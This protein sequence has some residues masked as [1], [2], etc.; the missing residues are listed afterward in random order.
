MIGGSELK[1]GMTILYNGD[2]CRVEYFQHVK[3]GKG[4][5]FT[6]TKLRNLATGA[7]LEYTFKT[8]ENIETAL[9]ERKE[10]EYLYRDGSDLYFMD[11]ESYEQLPFS[12]KRC[13]NIIPYL[14]ENMHV[15]VVMYEDKVLDI[16]V[17]NFV[18][19][20]VAKTDPGVKGDTAAGGSKPA[21]LETGGVVNVP[22]FIN[23]GDVIQIDT[24]TGE[25]LGR[26]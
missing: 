18:D 17:P 8:R 11:P 4:S 20:K 7:V 22:L 26:A 3:P 15:T 2:P 9:I 16:T 21:E 24:R 19:L 12:A 25:Y 6:R 14:K 10:M 23:E 1:N 5:A 13:K